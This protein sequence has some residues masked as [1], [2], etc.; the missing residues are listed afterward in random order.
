MV[1]VDLPRRAPSAVGQ[2]MLEEPLPRSALA[3]LAVGVVVP[4]LALVAAVPIAWGWG[5]SWLDLTIGLVAYLVTGFGV[6]VGLHRHFTTVRSRPRGGC[7]S[8]WRWP[9]A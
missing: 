8:P 3:A 6:A 7:G 2:P 9:A 5:L 4:F 1:V